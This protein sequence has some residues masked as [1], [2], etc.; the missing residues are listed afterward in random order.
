MTEFVFVKGKA[1]WFRHITPEVFTAPDGSTKESWKHTLYPDQDSLE[2]IRDLQSQGM[3]NILKKDE[4]G[5]YINF[6]RGT[7]QKKG[8]LL[9]RLDAPKV[10]LNDGKTEYGDMVGNGSDIIT[11]LEV[12][13]HRVPNQTKKSKAARWLSTRI[14]T[15]VPYDKGTP[16][17]RESH[18]TAA[19]QRAIKGLDKQPGIE[20]W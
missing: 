18:I 16:L 15:L 12:Y 9:V 17:D 5:Y 8:G 11:K 1:K 19:D 6:S 7:T 20:E 3:K 14:V 13:E 10:V 4:D 2:T